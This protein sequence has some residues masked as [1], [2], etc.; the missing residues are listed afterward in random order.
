M[1][2]QQDKINDIF[3][4]DVELLK[5]TETL[6]LKSKTTITT[7]LSTDQQL[8]L[9]AVLEWLNRAF[10]GKTEDNFFALTG[11]AGT[12]KT[13]LVDTILKSLPDKYL[14]SKVCVCAPTH[15][16]KKVIGEKTGWKILETLQALLGIKMDTNLE[17]FDPNNPAFNAIGERKM[18]N[19]WLV[20]IDE[21]SMVNTELKI[22]IEDCAKLSG[23]L[24]LYVG[25]TKQLNPVKEYTI[26]AALTSPINN[27]NLTQIMRQGEGN[28]LIV[29]LDA[30][31]YDIE[32]NTYTYIDHLK[33]LDTIGKSGEGYQVT[34]AQD[35]AAALKK[36]YTSDEFREN[37]NYCRYIAWTN[38]S[39]QTTN[40]YV[41]DKVFNFNNSTGELDEI[42]LS[43]KTIVDEDDIILTNS[44]DYIIEKIEDYIISDYTYPIQ[45]KH[46][47]LRGIDTGIV[48]KVN[49]LTKNLENY[50]NYVSIYRSELERAQRIGGKRGWSKFYDF[51]KKV[52][53]LENI[54]TGFKD[55]WNKDEIIKKDIDYGYGITI[56]KSQGST[57]NTV[58]VNGKDINRNSNELERKRL[59]YVALSRA[60]HK[61]Y[62]NL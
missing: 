4:L 26:S 35:F 36:Y 52:L 46:V 22:A 48:S 58:F 20:V 24:V 47:H 17:D 50:Q 62:I 56:H 5:Q 2:E 21:A 42:I 10:R 40:N 38:D 43:Y 7:N 15:K 31:R 57:Y 32:N 18:N 59:W 41:R 27:Y 49:L 53:V 19:Y 28:P 34:N 16:A 3:S 61:V 29:L 60:S 45:V 23:T 11:S 1:S 6:P 39:I 44:D 51:K 8:G 30:L 54:F 13:T 12:G 55:K 37:K 9:A 33:K 14:K 25:D